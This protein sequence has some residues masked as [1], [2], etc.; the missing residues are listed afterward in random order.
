MLLISVAMQYMDNE[1]DGKINT[2]NTAI[3]KPTIQEQP[4]KIEL[5]KSRQFLHLLV[6]FGENIVNFQT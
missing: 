6:S 5:K 4:V 2:V 1:V 3:N